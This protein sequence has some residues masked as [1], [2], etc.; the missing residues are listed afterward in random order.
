MTFKYIKLTP[1][2]Y[3]FIFNCKFFVLHSIVR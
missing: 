1:C 3:G 2:R